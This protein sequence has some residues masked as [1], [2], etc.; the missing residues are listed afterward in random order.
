MADSNELIKHKVVGAI[1]TILSIYGIFFL[2]PFHAGH[3]T[4]FSMN[5]VVYIVYWVLFFLNQVGFL[6][7]A[8]EANSYVLTH[9]ISF[10]ILNFI[11]SYF[12]SGHHYIVS[13]IILLISLV[14]S[15]VYYFSVNKYEDK[16]SLEGY[17]VR[18]AISWLFYAVFWNG[19]S[20]WGHF[21]DRLWFRILCNITIWDFL[22][23]PGL[24]I[25]LLNDYL[26]GTDTCI[27]VFGIA[28]KQLTHKV[29]ALQ[30]I[31]AFVVLGLLALLTVASIAGLF[32]SSSTLI[33]EVDEEQ[34]PLVT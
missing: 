5:H 23:I 11:W 17:L 15:L 10:G 33:V 27:L 26:V 16:V 32:R 2:H 21:N 25:L 9:L 18:F 29:F 19:S 8:N 24:F 28:L 6:V 34:R 22:I 14:N 13:E 12:Y 3:F 7:F 20:I 30:W 1:A 31:F 4:P